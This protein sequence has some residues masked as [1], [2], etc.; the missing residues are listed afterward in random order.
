M[1]ERAVGPAVMWLAM[2]APVFR[3]AMQAACRTFRS[4]SVM[5]VS[6]CESLMMPAGTPV[7]STPTRSSLSRK[8]AILETEALYTQS[9][10]KG[11][12]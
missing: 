2:A 1:T 8:S 7:F 4:V 3:E 9:G 5:P 11:S 6:F 10:M 12:R